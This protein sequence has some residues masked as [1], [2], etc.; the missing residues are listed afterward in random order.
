MITK[1][2]TVRTAATLTSRPEKSRRPTWKAVSA[3]RSPRPTEIFPNAVRVPV[4]TTTPLPAPWWTTVPMNAHD[5]RSRA[6]SPP[7]APATAFSTGCDSPVSTASSHS[8]WIASSSRR[9]AGTMSP[10]RIETTSPGTSCAVGAVIWTPSRQTR[11]VWRMPACRA[12]TAF[13]ARYSLTKPRPTLRRTMTVM[14]TAS[15]GAPVRPETP[16]AASRRI[17]SGLWS[18][19]T[20]TPHAV[21]RCTRR[22]LRPTACRRAAASALLSPPSSLP[23]RASTTSGGRPPASAIPRGGG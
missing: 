15:V 22:A 20:R 2:D 11:A 17:R 23:S 13:A 3:C 7:G 14:I 21:T 9:S 5:D 10:T 16:A 4:E 18:W 8:S 1:I 19:R 6:E 12:A